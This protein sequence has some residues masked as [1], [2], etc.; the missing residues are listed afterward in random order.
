MFKKFLMIQRHS[1]E[2]LISLFLILG[3]FSVFWPV[4]ILAPA[5]NMQTF[6]FP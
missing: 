4:L 3:A 6:G 1:P 2:R 5:H